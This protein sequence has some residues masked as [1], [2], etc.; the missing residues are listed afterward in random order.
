MEI[1]VSG[2]ADSAVYGKD[3]VCAGVSTAVTGIANA[4][5]NRHFLEGLGTIDLKEGFVHIKVN[6]FDHDVEVVLETFETILDTIEES[7]S[8]YMKI[9]KMEV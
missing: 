4:L 2:H 9:M 1:T 6:Q 8:R 3:L 5:V 7:Y